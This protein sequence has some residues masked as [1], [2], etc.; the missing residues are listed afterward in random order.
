MLCRVAHRLRRR[1]QAY[2]RG[3]ALDRSAV[4]RKALEPLFT[5][6]S[7]NESSLPAR[8]KSHTLPDEVHRLTPRYLGWG[9]G[10]L[11]EELWDQFKEFLACASACRKLY[12]GNQPLRALY[13][14]LLMLYQALESERDV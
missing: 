2:C 1:L 7:G 8:P 3:N 14:T 5:T 12:P 9:S 6:N 4:I 13:E 10:D 11:R